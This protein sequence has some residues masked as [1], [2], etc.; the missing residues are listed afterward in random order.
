MTLACRGTKATRTNGVAL[1]SR[2]MPKTANESLVTLF[3]IASGLLPLACA[4]QKLPRE[5][6]ARSLV[7]SRVTLCSSSEFPPD[8]HGTCVL[9]FVS[10]FAWK[11]DQPTHR[12]LSAP[13][14]PAQFSRTTMGCTE[15]DAEF[16][17]L[18]C[19][20]CTTVGL[21]HAGSGFTSLV[22]CKDH[23]TVRKLENS[24]TCR[25]PA[26][27]RSLC[28]L[29]GARMHATNPGNNVNEPALLQGL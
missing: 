19:P 27:K 22:G 11:T 7:D 14:W 2:Q 4:F 8:F 26:P 29:A 12:P 9:H 5:G 10:D 20:C 23:G 18:A 21:P 24:M 25:L 28:D 13:C 6:R 1:P 17:H 15:Q 16:I 3:A